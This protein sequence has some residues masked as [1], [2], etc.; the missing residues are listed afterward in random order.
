MEILIIFLFQSNNSCSY[1]LTICQSHLASRL[2]HSC[3]PRSYYFW[4]ISKPHSGALRN[5]SFQVIWRQMIISIKG[6]WWPSPQQSAKSVSMVMWYSRFGA[7][8]LGDDYAFEF[9]ER[10]SFEA[11]SAEGHK[12]GF[13]VIHTQFDENVKEVVAIYGSFSQNFPSILRYLRIFCLDLR[14]EVSSFEQVADRKC[15]LW[16]CAIW[17]TLRLHLATSCMF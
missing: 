3:F 12:A 6:W 4:D 10:L 16:R 9:W 5:G 15:F 13:Y 14:F 17:G 7:L 1:L 8:I 2:S 11:K